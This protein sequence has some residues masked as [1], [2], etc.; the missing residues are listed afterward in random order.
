MISIFNG[1]KR[2][3]GNA[4]A[5]VFAQ[6]SVE[7]RKYLY[8]FRGAR[9]HVF[10]CIAL[11]ADDKGWAY[12]GIETCLKRE[13]GYN[14]DTIT[15][16]LNDLCQLVI[17]GHRVLLAYQPLR[18]DGTF[19]SNQYLIFPSVDEVA[20]YETNNPR[21]R[22][23]RAKSDPSMENHVSASPRRGFPSTVK[24][25]T[26][27]PNTG[28]HISKKNQSGP[29]PTKLKT[30]KRQPISNAVVDGSLRASRVSASNIKNDKA[31]EI[32]NPLVFSELINA[33]KHYRVDEPARTEIAQS[34]AQRAFELDGVGE[35]R[36][37]TGRII[38]CWR[39]C[40][41]KSIKDPQAF[42]VYKLR[43][44]DIDYLATGDEKA[45]SRVQTQ[46]SDAVEM[47][48]SIEELLKSA[49]R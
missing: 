17:E 19:Q 24:P 37:M 44:L 26:V 5:S 46:A 30:S 36:K 32:T 29:E 48:K 13:T 22:Q 10:L 42:F 41:K 39:A 35:W 9:M 8:L 18:G 2:S 3:L 38:N 34:L 40:L 12:P 15:L 7:F 28:I 43:Q 25:S 1:R 23:N 49:R 27:I 45:L 14:R 20:Q 4:E 47:I 33:L 6:I 21:R 31:V 16:A 11:H